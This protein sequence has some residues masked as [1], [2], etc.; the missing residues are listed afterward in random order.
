VGLT[1]QPDGRLKLTV[2]AYQI[3][4]RNRI[5]A[6]SNLNLSAANLASSTGLSPLLSQFP[7]GFVAQYFTNA[8]D[9]KTRGIDAVADYPVDLGAFGSVDLSVAYTYT[10]TR[11]DRI[12]ATPSQVSAFGLTLYDRQ[13]QGNLTVGTPQDKVILTGNWSRGPWRASLRETRYGPWTETNSAT[14]PKLDRH[15][16]AKWISALEIGR[17]FPGGREVSIGAENLFDI[18]PDHVGVI[19]AQTG[20]GLYG[21]LSPFGITGGYYYARFTQKL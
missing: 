7:F 8:V 20:A 21:N 11:I 2:D 15:F 13:K 16:G 5:V 19:N 1:A 4:I 17:A 3:D 14:D 18:Q 12:Q 9:T 10:N 6:T